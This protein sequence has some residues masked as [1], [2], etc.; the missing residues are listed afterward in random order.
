PK[1]GPSAGVAM[2]CALIS[3]LT[4]RPLRNDVAMTGE[5]TI[6]GRVLPIGGLK[7]KALG[8]LRAGI[9]TVII[10][11]KNRKELSELPAMLRRKLKFI[12]VSRVEEILELALLPPVKPP[13]PANKPKKKTRAA[14]KKRPAKSSPPVSP[15]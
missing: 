3:V 2:V 13:A 15:V 14:A 8:A 5:V 7:E 6:R 12:S 11:E 10:P 1:D 9:K 4:N